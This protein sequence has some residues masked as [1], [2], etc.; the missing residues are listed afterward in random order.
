MGLIQDNKGAISIFLCIILMANIMLAGI[1]IEGTRMKWAESQI[2]EATEG[3]A[4]SSLAGY[5]NMLKNLFGIFALAENDTEYLEDDIEFYLNNNLMTEL[6][7]NKESMNDENSKFLSGLF[8]NRGDFETANFFNPYDYRIENMEVNQINNLTENKILKQQILEY[9]K[10]RAPKQLAEGFLDKVISIKDFGEQSQLMSKKTRLDKELNRICQYQKKLSD[11]IEMINK[12]NTSLDTDFIKNKYMQIGIEKCKLLITDRVA[13][14]KQKIREKEKLKKNEI[15]QMTKKINSKNSEAKKIIVNF[16]SNIRTYIENN[17]NGIRAIDNIKEYSEAT[18]DKM[19]EIINDDLNGDNSDFAKEMRNEVQS[20][21]DQLDSKRLDQIKK[22]IEDNVDILEDLIAIL[23]GLKPAGINESRISSTDRKKINEFIGKEIKSSELYKLVLNYE[24]TCN[25][26]EIEYIKSEKTTK[27][28]TKND[29]RKNSESIVKNEITKNKPNKS[30]KSKLTDNDLVSKTKEQ[31][32]KEIKRNKKELDISD[33]KYLESLFGHFG[34]LHD[35]TVND[36]T[37]TD[38]SHNKS[39]KT[40]N[41]NKIIDSVEFT[42]DKKK[43]FSE[44]GLNFFANLGTSI[45]DNI[46]NIRDNLYINEYILGTFK[47]SLTLSKQKDKKMTERDLRDELMDKRKTYFNTSEVEYILTGNKDERFNEYAIKAEILLIR[48]A[49]NTLYIYMDAQKNSIALE[50]A[51]I[52]AGWTGFGVP[53]VQ[54]LIMLGWAMAESVIDVTNIMNGEKVPLYKTKDTWVLSETSMIKAFIGEAAEKAKEFAEESVDF[55][56]NSAAD[57]AKTMVKR[58]DDL[59][60]NKIKIAVDNVFAPIENSVIQM[61]NNID[62]TFENLTNPIESV[63]GNN[64]STMGIIESKIN[65]YVLRK[66]QNSKKTLKEKLIKTPSD[67]AMEYIYYMKQKIC[68]EIYSEISKFVK[69]LEKE[70]NAVSMKSKDKI[71]RFIESTFGES[72]NTKANNNFKSCILSL[73]YKDYLRIFLLV[74][75]EDTKL[76]RIED[77]IQLNMRKETGYNRF[78]LMNYNTSIRVEAIISYKYM[79]APNL[80]RNQNPG[81]GFVNRHVFKTVFYKGY[82]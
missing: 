2:Q 40:Q 35:E 16:I 80:L 33:E 61:T 6:G 37:N 24:G 30:K 26:R 11:C 15:A 9:M 63:I 74:K 81:K 25:K 51:T 18:L 36:N 14:E 67:R 55:G 46:M 76:D 78:L 66:F 77:L 50:T 71:N 72:G 42:E 38:S 12:F 43:G 75:G 34:L 44:N 60:K 5:Q 10:Y 20:K 73:D 29:P 27:S 56:I 82:Y 4:V 59:I 21:K 64:S 39:N 53:I 54:T 31:N 8:T 22:K 23:N 28:N 52:I 47:N 41:P 7:I 1:L 79:F 3:A 13:L 17:K 49:L 45:K 19:D 68:S 57:I 58:A 65:E 69:K 70:I 62:N 32:E 48:F